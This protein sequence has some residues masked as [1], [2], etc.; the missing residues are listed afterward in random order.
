MSS[1]LHISINIKIGE[2]KS[3]IWVWSFCVT[4]SW[5]VNLDLSILGSQ[6][7]YVISS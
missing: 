2:L 5:D 4:M 6:L 3:V 1:Q 7:Q